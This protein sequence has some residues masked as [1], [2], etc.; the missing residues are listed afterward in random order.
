MIRHAL[1]LTILVLAHTSCVTGI[2]Y[3]GGFRPLSVNSKERE[4]FEAKKREFLQ[5]EDLKIGTGPLAA[6]GRKITA[7]VVIR[8]ASDGTLAYKGPMLTYWGTSGGVFIHNSLREAGALDLQQLGILLGLNGMTVGGKR[9]FTIAPRL[10]CGWGGPEQSD[11]H[12]NCLL[13][14]GSKDIVMVRIEALQVEATLTGACAPLHRKGGWDL[15]RDSDLPS[16]DPSDPIWRFYY[17]EPLQ[18]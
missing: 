9:R 14:S 18:P 17:A 6:Y 8:Y 13:V 11:R 10:V 12:G 1:L 7:D 15:C 3:E 4:M 16:R 5:I 2:E